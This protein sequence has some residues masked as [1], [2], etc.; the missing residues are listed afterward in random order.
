MKITIIYDN[1]TVV[2]GLTSDWG[3]AC[4]VEFEGKN[5]LFDT[6]GK[7]EILLSNMEKLNIAPEIIDLIFISHSHWDHTGGISDILKRKSARLY[8][9]KG[10][11]PPSI[12]KDVIT[13]TGP[14]R[15]AENIHSTGVLENIEQTLV[16]KTAKGVVIIAGCSHPG[17][18]NILSVASQF[19][20]CFALI[21]GLHG[22]DE[23]ELLEDITVVCPTHCTR[24]IDDIKKKYPEKYIEGGAGRVIEI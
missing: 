23:F 20:K 14:V 13:V 10:Y 6:G 3:F 2:E 12:A 21:G 24:Q 7:G 17:V 9:P 5:I 22:F 15:I 16:V 18:G 4:L 1:T 8:I 19:G 11:D